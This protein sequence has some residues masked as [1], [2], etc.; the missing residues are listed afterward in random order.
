MTTPNYVSSKYAGTDLDYLH[1]KVDRS[2]ALRMEYFTAVIPTTAVATEYIGLVPFQKGARFVQG[3]SQLHVT[4]IDSSTDVTLDFGYIY[5]DDTTYTNDPNA[6]GTLITTGQTGGLVT[7]DEHAG[8]S[9]QAEA[10]GWIVAY[11]AAGSD[12]DVGTI[13]GQIVLAYD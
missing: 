8:L 9:F 5:D 13:K 6:F 10:N 4:D 1:A 12:V 7:F 2:G 3:A 11:I